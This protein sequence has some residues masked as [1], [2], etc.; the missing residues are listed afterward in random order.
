VIVVG[1]LMTMVDVIAI[2][3]VAE[4]I[5]PE[6]F[7]A[8]MVVLSRSG[9]GGKGDRPCQPDRRNKFL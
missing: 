5:V 8:H 6:I 3:V 1:M 9:D 7:V 2:M 4:M